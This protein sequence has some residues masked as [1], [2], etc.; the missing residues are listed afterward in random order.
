MIEH[1]TYGTF[2]FFGLFIFLGALFIWLFCPETKQ[3][4]LEE[5]DAVFGSIGVVAADWQLIEEINK[6]IGL[7]QRI[8]KRET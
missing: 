2:I 1:L 7:K 3:L 6:E 5:M 8:N 4:T